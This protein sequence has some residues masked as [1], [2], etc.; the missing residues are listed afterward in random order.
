MQV[1][2]V[3][4][5][6]GKV[7]IVSEIFSHI[8]NFEGDWDLVPKSFIGIY[9]NGEKFDIDLD[10]HWILLDETPNDYINRHVQRFGKLKVCNKGEKN[11]RKI[12]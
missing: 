4:V 3:I 10:K 9:L 8:F 5:Y 6:D 1:G 11:E 12:V 2:N 7:G